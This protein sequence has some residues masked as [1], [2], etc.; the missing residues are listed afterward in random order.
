MIPASV[1]P[2]AGTDV[3]ERA[4]EDLNDR[5]VACA[6]CPRLSAYRAQ[7]AGSR[8]RALA[9]W[10]YWARPVPGF[11]DRRAR[12]LVL[13]LAPAAHG[14]NRTGRMFTGDEAGRFLVA[15]L[16]RAGF[17]SQPTSEHRGD[18]LAL[19][20]AF[21]TAPVRCAPPGNRPSREE[22]DRCFP[23]LAEEF[24]LLRRVEVI[25]ALGRVAFDAARRL[26]MARLDAEARRV[27]RAARF[28]HG[29][30]VRPAPRAPAL[31]AC[32]HPSRHNTATGRLTAQ[33]MDE[34]LGR[35]RVLLGVTLPP[36]SAPPA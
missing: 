26:L 25:L 15:A 4:W 9:S 19:R 1:G 5:I 29:Q 34:V 14:A 7:V 31:V 17:A 23:Y 20:D 28:R 33:M 30:V 22:M 24:A 11:G 13:G 21:V 16:W 32:Y 27:L 2:D 6:A 8:P 18:G 10:E 12:L 3:P 36:G 35:V